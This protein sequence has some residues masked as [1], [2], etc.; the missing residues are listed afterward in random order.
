MAERR[1]I[2][3]ERIPEDG[4]YSEAMAR[5]RR[6]PDTAALRISNLP[7]LLSRIEHL[8]NEKRDCALNEVEFFIRSQPPEERTIAFEELLDAAK[9]CPE[10]LNLLHEYAGQRR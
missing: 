2:G 6:A 10:L 5:A 8:M 3:G 7:F 1:V 9:D 4:G